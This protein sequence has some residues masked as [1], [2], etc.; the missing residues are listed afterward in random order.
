M[1]KDNHLE[2]TGGEPLGKASQAGKEA[3]GPKAATPPVAGVSASQFPIIAIGASAGGLNA[4]A[5]LLDVMPR[6]AA[7]AFLLVQHLDPSH[8]S[9]MV[10]LLGT[11]TTMPIHQAKD[12]MTLA[13]GEIY[14]C[15]PGHYMEVRFGVLRLSRARAGQHARLPIDCLVRSLAAECG[16]R[17]VCIILS[18]TGADGS[19][20]LSALRNSGGHVIV[21]DPEE[22]EYNGMP[23][24]AIQTGFANAVAP[25]DSI[26]KELMKIAA[27]IALA[28]ST[29]IAAPGIIAA[30]IQSII[31]IL[32]KK[33]GQDFSA[34]KRGTLERRIQ[35]R[36]GL[37]G[38]PVSSLASYRDELANN[39]EECLLLADDLLINVTGFFRDP[40]V[41]DLLEREVISELIRELPA[42]QALRLWV[43]GCSSGEEA[44]S[45]AMI[46]RDAIIASRRDIRL[47]VFASDID[48]QAIATARSGL[49]PLSIKDE[50][51]VDKL[52]RYFSREE[53]GYRVTPGLRGS[54]V[55]TVQDVLHDP[56]FSR[57]D[58]VSCRNM[59]IYFKPEAQAKV[60][61]LF[62]FAL[63]KNGVLLL[64]QA[65]TPGNTNGYF[66]EFHKVERIYRH[67]A[68][69]RP[70][71]PGF[72]LSFVESIPRISM[73]DGGQKPSRQ[74][75]LADLCCGAVIDSFAP[76]SV[77]VDAHR[78]FIYSL[79]PV[80]R[81]LRLASGPPTLDLLTLAA[82]DLRATLRH[83][84][85]R[86][87]R[88]HPF[89]KTKVCKTEY[90]GQIVHFAIEVRFLTSEDE[91]LH[92]VSFVEQ[93]PSPG[94]VP[95]RDEGR[96]IQELERELEATQADL[97]RAIHSRDALVLEQ[98]AIN[99][100]ALSV[101][102]EFQST[103]EELLTSKE[104][105]QSL[106]EELIALNSQLQET[107]D[108]QRIASDDLQNILYSTNVATLFLDTALCIRFFTPATRAIFSVIP[109]DIGRP[110]ADL[111][112][113][114][115][116]RD[117]LAD[118]RLVLSE[119]NIIEREISVSGGAW[120]LRRISPYRTHD[121]R[122]EGVVI[123][124][125]DITD[126]RRTAAALEDARREAEQS[127]R[128]KS[129]FLAVASHDL[130]Q[131]LQS[132]RLIQ[133]MLS[134]IVQDDTGRELIAR[135][136][137]LLEAMTTML[138]S[139]LDINQI[140][141]GMMETST[142]TFPAGALLNQLKAEFDP[143]TE[144]KGLALR[145]VP[146][147]DLLQS[148]QHLLEV[149][150]RNLLANALKYTPR[151][152]ILMGCRRVG[153]LIRI[154]VWDTGIGI[155]EDQ[156]Q[157]IFDEFHQVDNPARERERGFGLGLT[158]VRELGQ[159]L[160][161]AVQVRS[162]PG[163]GS[164]FSVTV[165]RGTR[166]QLPPPPNPVP[167]LP[168]PAR[169][170]LGC[171]ILV[172]EDDPYVLDS[173]QLLLTVSGHTI[174]TAKDGPSALSIVRKGA[175]RPDI[176]LTDYNLPG[177]MNG[178]EVL[179]S[180]RADLKDDVP[181]IVLTGDISKD[182]LSQI[183][184]ADCILLSKPVAA[185]AFHDAIRRVAPAN[186]H[187]LTA[188]LKQG[189]RTICVVEDNRD[190]C[191]AIRSVLEHDEQLVATYT[192][193]EAFLSDHDAGRDKCLVV[194]TNLPGMSGIALIEHLR[195]LGDKVPVILITGSGDVGMAVKAM[196][197]GASDFIER[198]V[199]RRDLI[200][201]IE[202]AL[203]QASSG[204][205][206]YVASDEV[207]GRLAALT[208]RQREV[209]DMVLAGQPSKNIAADLGIA[210]RTVESHRAQIMKRI[211]VR[212]IPE[213][214]RTVLS[215]LPA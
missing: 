197:S 206:R 74:V 101:N 139:L 132:L 65:E 72:P 200:E 48:A 102:E 156:L 64:G 47:Q 169:G 100:E 187:T 150:L 128:G 20:A 177:G 46:C 60:I 180:L 34:Y 141:A 123:T 124:F 142:T 41:F 80:S 58:L 18:G 49:Y 95:I 56:P 66:K 93:E 153:G 146:C 213:L 44:Y 57:I 97:L 99:D 89:F 178:V 129:R 67:V 208:A 10:E 51:P 110:L 212:T 147:A 182:S 86:V 69:S 188:D 36:I 166:A 161:H 186:P 92:L 91:D 155:P 45:L 105:L 136:G 106:N 63:R 24:S 11:H 114:A 145:V 115:D 15:P 152:T 7:M 21:Q 209:L 85:N 126:R 157:N 207:A 130:R 73:Q 120:F 125:V 215:A 13:P 159:L 32:Q 202:R 77:L 81:Y 190:M 194:D 87:D 181:G 199:S 171:T 203:A 71:E 116:D 183:E 50:V 29:A 17:T 122:V 26:P 61:S 135:F 140:E 173:L 2:T 6:D 14:V 1:Q 193:A 121:D 167:E 119:S 196:R 108:R 83:A 22:A 90:E 52:S 94:V 88:D 204:V 25:L 75:A 70:S 112:S 184:M 160:G 28:S 55:F 165:P 134:Q 162:W 84:I 210:Q 19:G 192:S 107:L 148:D 4:T 185:S 38:L 79:G 179:A 96:Q 39:A 201:S 31:A 195:A 158:I 33:T 12:G 53:D 170:T 163:K 40:H 205:S 103:N 131:P 127:N 189:P 137:H 37:C 133:E 76:A 78:Q 168:T 104:E 9:Q 82:P 23:R 8:E 151:G 3:D 109:G 16:Q 144:A 176:V 42:D 164:V 174:I 149:M 138:N 211:G 54:V 111:R 143:Q 175:I 62:H 98:K 154:E 118:A 30:D 117:L 68:R 214:V 43:V 172:I 191:N 59:L 113:L 198:P 35:R 27:Q 5:R